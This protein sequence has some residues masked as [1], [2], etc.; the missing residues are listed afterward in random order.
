[1]VNERELAIISHLRKDSR[2]SL[3]FISEEI[4]MPPSTIY[5]KINRLQRDDVIKSYTVMLDFK[6]L[7]LNHHAKI[8]LKINKIYHKK[9][10]EYLKKHNI[11]NSISQINSGFDFMVETLSKDI[12]EYLDFID[13]VKIKFGVIDLYDYLIVDEIEK[14]KIFRLI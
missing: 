1:M 10:L 5:D 11:V 12:K 4:E 13:E 9:L 3:A 7:G 14:E 6:K 8:V 2:T